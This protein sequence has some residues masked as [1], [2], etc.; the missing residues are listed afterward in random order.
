MTPQECIELYLSH[1]VMGFNR[2]P[3]DEK[4]YWRMG[5]KLYCDNLPKVKKKK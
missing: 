5:Q 2:L 4:E 3:E 1:S